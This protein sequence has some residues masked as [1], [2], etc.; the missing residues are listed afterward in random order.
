MGN[1]GSSQK[2]WYGHYSLVSIEGRMAYWKVQQGHDRS[3]RTKQVYV[4]DIITNPNRADWSSKVGFQE[5]SW[6][7]LANDKT[8]KLLDV[9]KEVA[10]RLGK[11]RSQVALRWLLQRPGVTAPIVGP[12]TLEQA[13]DNF[14]IY[15]WSIPEADMKLLNEA[16][17][18]A[19]PYPYNWESTSYF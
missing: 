10:T 14:A 9:L 15:D 18:P 17:Q 8:W 13:L 5:T 11:T 19:V 12:K 2:A 3:S 4:S 1:F 6:K 7:S 16:S